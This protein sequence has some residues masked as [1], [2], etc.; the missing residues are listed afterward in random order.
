MILFT[1]ATSEQGYVRQLEDGDEVDV[2]R[3]TIVSSKRASEDVDFD[4]D[5]PTTA[6][7]VEALRR[8]RP[9]ADP[10]ILQHL[11]RL[12]ADRLSPKIQPR[13]STSKG[14]EPFEL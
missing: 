5:V 2:S 9:V 6:A 10:E 11:D 3:S 7:D 8:S 14:W 1:L 4:R 13:R 12:R